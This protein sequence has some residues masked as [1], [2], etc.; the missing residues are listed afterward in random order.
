VSVRIAVVQ[1]DHNP[2]AVEENRR[3]A[4]GVAAEALYRGADV[5]LFHEELLAGYANNPRSLAEPVNGTTTRQFQEA[6][7]GS[8]SQVIYG[9]TERDGDDYY[10]AAAVIGADGLRAHY[11]KTHLWWNA[12]GP[13]FE[14]G[15]YRAGD[16]WT[17]FDVRGFRSGV[18]ICYDGDFLETTRSYANLDCV[19]LFWMN[20]RGSRGYEETRQ[21]AELNSM[22]MATACCCGRNERG[23]ICRGGSNIVDASGKLL[24]ELW[25]REGIIYADV[26]PG[27]V[28]SLRRRNFSYIGQRQD[29]YR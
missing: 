28:M 24:A 5:I 21:K 17:T 12:T 19:M 14:P 11:R 9:L 1:Q 26:D 15:Q 27:E 23:E 2:G 29:L 7:R 10:I 3:K 25:D 13:R 18:M 22:I 20:N 6:L 16:H 8:T 4:L